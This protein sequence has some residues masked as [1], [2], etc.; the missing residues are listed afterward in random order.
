M[1]SQDVLEGVWRAK[2][3]TLNLS[4]RDIKVVPA[5]V[6]RL[7]FVK[8]LLLNDNSILMP[9]EEVTHLRQLECLS[10]ECNQ[11]TV[12]PSGIALLSSTLHFLNLS[13]NPLTSVSPAVGRLENLRSLWLAHTGL[14][15]FPEE[16]CSLC[17]L[18]HL[19]L[20]GNDIS[21]ITDVAPIGKLKK[22]KWL[23]VAKNKLKSVEGLYTSLP[24]LHT[25]NLSDNLLTAIPRLAVCPVLCTLN[26]RRNW[27]SLLPESIGDVTVF[28]QRDNTLKLDLRDNPMLKERPSWTLQEN[29]FV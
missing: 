1:M 16:V 18:T 27:L 9:P 2:E 6:A 7:D 12:L 21:S 23:S 14:V 28:K 25:L 19:S 8:V 15:S 13:H 20:A 11:L 10:L 26:L 4:H 3:T 17:N 5:E 29:V 22:L 24:C